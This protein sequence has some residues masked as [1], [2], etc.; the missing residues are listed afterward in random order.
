MAYPRFWKLQTHRLKMLSNV[1]SFELSSGFFS[2]VYASGS[3]AVGGASPPPE[4]VE[5]PVAVDGAGEAA[6]SLLL[7]P[8][9]G[10]VLIISQRE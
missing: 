2:F 10:E 4:A 8:R 6:L 7:K 1:F 3:E 5:P 9:E